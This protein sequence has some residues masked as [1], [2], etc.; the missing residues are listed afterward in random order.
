MALPVY[1]GAEMA[2]IDKFTIE[3]IGIPGVVLMENAGRGAAR[4]IDIEMRDRG[5]DPYDTTVV[6]VC[7]KGNNGGDGF[8]VSRYLEKFGYQV[9]THLLGRKEEVSGDAAIMMNAY[10]SS[11]GEVFEH[12]DEVKRELLEDLISCDAAVD[13][14]FG[15]GLSKEVS[16]R[17]LEAIKMFGFVPG[18]VFAIDVPSGVD[19]STG[20]VLGEA[21]F[22]DVT[23]TFGYMKLGHIIDPGFSRSGEVVVVDI[24]IPPV[25]EDVIPP[26]HHLIDLD[27]F[28]DALIPRRNNFHK[29]DAGRVYVI[30]GSRG[31]TGA[32]VMACEG[33]LAAGSGLIY[34]VIPGSL[35]DVLENKM[36][37]QLTI[38]VDDE[39]KGHFLPKN[40]VSILE[41]LERA[42]AV[43]LGPGLSWRKETAELVRELIREIEVPMVLDADGINV[44]SDNPDVLKEKKAPLILTPHEMEMARLLGE[45]VNYVSQ[46][47][48]EAARE[49]ADRFGVV[50]LL[51]GFRTVIATPD[52]EVYVNPTGNPYMATGGMG[53]VLTGI[54]L[55]FLGQ[56]I[57][58]VLSACAGA[59]IHGMVGDIVREKYPGCVVAPRNVVA[60]YPEAVRSILMELV[61][62]VED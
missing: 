51:K 27:D 52:G 58:P 31:M 24:G 41:R 8:V 20:K 40:S 7:G 12:G 54:I 38:P 28:L 53:D 13:A 44:L 48:I 2:R 21:V 49:C 14:I 16:G 9:M 59:F 10:L 47:R 35:N 11:G 30:G 55:S 1:T 26:I 45:D 15:T 18:L 42:H 50:T 32:V 57:D 5:F 33:A 43:A 4:V 23:I 25:A 62:D 61:E 37:E 36:T 60:Y 29:G 3:N 6:V 56:R 17:Y 22:A 19:S 34:A 46:N 39:G